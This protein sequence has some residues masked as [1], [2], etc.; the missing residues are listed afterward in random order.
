VSP[1]FP[2]DNR[3]Y[4]G[5]STRVKLIIPHPPWRTHSTT[6]GTTA[7]ATS[8]QVTEDVIHAFLC[9]SA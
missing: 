8:D 4:A 9:C 6:C 2:S 5:P 3:P 1:F 7:L